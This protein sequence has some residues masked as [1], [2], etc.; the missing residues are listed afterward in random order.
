MG[1]V[2]AARAA[3][4]LFTVLPV[5]A[6]PLERRSAGLTMML[7]PLV[8]AGVGASAAGVVLA[9]RTAIDVDAPYDVLIAAAGI[10][11]LSAA[12][13]GLHLD[14]L[15]D[16]ADGLGSYRSAAGAGAIMRR[17]DIGPFGVIALVVTLLL[18]V[19]ALVG[20]LVAHRVTQGLV[21]AAMTGGLSATVASVGVPA[22]RPD[23]LGALVARS[24]TRWQAVLAVTV[25]V[26][27]AALAGSIDEGS[28]LRGAVRGVAALVVG[29]VVALL[30]LRHAVRRLGGVSGDVFGAVIEVGLTTAL[31][32]VAVIR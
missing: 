15:A 11:A 3:L 18:Q 25:S 28:G 19:G 14:G 17:G 9:L 20:A 13:R 5:P 32:A 7:A 29:L 24:V 31:V 27:I 30:F 12:S 2:D 23:G 1:I 6:R 4:S 26:A 22:A 10:A 16:T 8:G 21:I